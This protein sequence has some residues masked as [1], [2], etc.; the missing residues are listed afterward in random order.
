[1]GTTR[2]FILCE[3]KDSGKYVKEEMSVIKEWKVHHGDLFALGPETNRA[4]CHAVTQ[5]KTIQD[6]RISIIF[7]TVT[8][9]FIDYNVASK[10]VTYAN[11][12][13]KEFKAECILCK[14][15]HDS[16][17]RTH[18]ADLIDMREQKKLS[19]IQSPQPKTDDESSDRN[20]DTIENSTEVSDSHCAEGKEA[21]QESTNSEQLGS[22]SCIRKSHS[23][24][25]L[26]KDTKSKNIVEDE[27]NANSYKEN[28]DSEMIYD[29]AK[30]INPKLNRTCHN[31]H[32]RFLDEEDQNDYFMGRG[33]EVPAIH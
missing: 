28:S 32:I 16:G 21:V 10:Y 8:K 9:S 1:M 33:L 19:K 24:I 26:L 22:S 27:N 6:V 31:Q 23:Q 13:I 17:S 5:D 3:N 14:D 7:R 29:S 30:V 4:Y 2:D 25:F 15:L 20:K 12:K 18:V 11:G